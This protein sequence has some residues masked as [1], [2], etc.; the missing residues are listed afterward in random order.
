MGIASQL[1][2]LFSYPAIIRLLL[3]CLCYFR[4]PPLLGFCFT[5]V[6]GVGEDGRGLPD[7]RCGHYV[8]RSQT[9]RGRAGGQGP[10]Q[11]HIWYGYLI[12]CVE[13]LVD[14]DRARAIFGTVTSLI[15]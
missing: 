5:T 6:A 9:V 11:G 13:N 7:G 14:K 3:R 10:R 4:I 1:F 15:V 12:N 8:G 2:L